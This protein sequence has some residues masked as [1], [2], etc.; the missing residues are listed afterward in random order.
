MLNFMY[1]LKH[2]PNIRSQLFILTFWVGFKYHIYIYWIHI[3]S[4]FYP[5]ENWICFILFKVTGLLYR[6]ENDMRETTR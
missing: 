2:P 5:D 6:E 1:F 3:K 4:F